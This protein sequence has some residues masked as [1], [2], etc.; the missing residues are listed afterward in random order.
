MKAF[1]VLQ[2]NLR[3]GTNS[4]PI[5]AKDFCFLHEEEN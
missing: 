4:L 2:W 5:D 1:N 3:A